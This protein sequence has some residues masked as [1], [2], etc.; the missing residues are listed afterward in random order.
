L[1]DVSFSFLWLFAFFDDDF[2]EEGE[3]YWKWMAWM[4]MR[5]DG[6]NWDTP[7]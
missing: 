3:G 7:F 5:M 2:G 1:Y 4:M 6:W